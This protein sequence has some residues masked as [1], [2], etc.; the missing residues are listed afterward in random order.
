[1][2][3]GAMSV[4]ASSRVSASP[5]MAWS[6]LSSA[7]AW[8]LR[9]GF[10]AFDGAVPGSVPIR[11]LLMRTKAGVMPAVLT[12]CSEQPGVA[13]TWRVAGMDQEF[14]F[15]VS[16]HRRRVTV[17]IAINGPRDRAT[18]REEKARFGRM[19]DMW[20]ARA[21]L[22][23]E[24]RQPWP[25]GMPA[26]L[27]QAC[28]PRPLPEPTDSASAS[29]II[30][31]PLEAVWDAVWGPSPSDGL[32]A[33]GHIP[34]TPVQEVGEMQYFLFRPTP[35]SQLLLSS[36][37]VRAIEYQRSAITQAI[38]VGR[39][40]TSYLLTAQPDGIRLELTSRWAPTAKAREPETVRTQM[41][42]YVRSSA[43]SYKTAIERSQRNS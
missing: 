43:S 9:P 36:V 7:D 21:C 18:A 29:V 16:P 40:E 2:A 4:E 28:A 27:R 30:A 14:T 1:M 5:E 32:V 42:E 20:L 10:F 22:V 34:A 35:D 24:D 31:A 13:A 8:C 19:L 6:L 11:C 3:D 17:T 25:T 26:A 37:I 39:Q 33:W 12:L 41:I 23:L 38:P 15:S